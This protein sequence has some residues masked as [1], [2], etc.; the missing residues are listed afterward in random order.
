MTVQAFVP[1][2]MPIQAPPGLALDT[3]DTPLL[4]ENFSD[5][6]REVCGAPPANA[7]V[8][9]SEIRLNLLCMKPFE[10]WNSLQAST[11]EFTGF[12][13]HQQYLPPRIRPY[14]PCKS[15]DYFFNGFSVKT[16]ILVG[17]YNQQFQGTIILM[18]FD[19]QGKGG[20]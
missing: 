13:N 20:H 7:T 11:G 14:K 10:T 4:G 1:V 19:F 17:I 2:N 15:K 3:D 18:V 5:L 12:L 16:I 9:G 6:K 8:D